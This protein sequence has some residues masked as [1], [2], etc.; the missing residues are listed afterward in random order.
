MRREIGVTFRCK[1]FQFGPSMDKGFVQIRIAK[2]P[3]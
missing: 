2:Y 1:L 3:D